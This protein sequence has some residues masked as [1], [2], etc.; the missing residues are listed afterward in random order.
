MTEPSATNSNLVDE[1]RLRVLERILREA[2]RV[3]ALSDAPVA[4]IINHAKWFADAIPHTARTAVDLGSGAGVPGL[5]VA[6]YCPHLSL[7]LVDRRVGRTDVLV[8]A[9]HALNLVDRVTVRCSEITDMTKDSTWAKHF[10]VAMSR[11]LGPP[12]QTL[13]LS[14]DL[15]KPGGAIIISEPPPDSD[16]RWD[17]QQVRALGL[18]GPSRIGAVAMFHVK[19]FGS[20]DDETTAS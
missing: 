1:S 5:I 10:D 3:G 17:K 11:G 12:I 19:Q 4:E 6:L 16:S 2:Q 20:D 7:H 9:V 8:R 15:V 13:N 18:E 14:R